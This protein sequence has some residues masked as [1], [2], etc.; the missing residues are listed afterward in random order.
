VSHCCRKTL[1][2]WAESRG[3]RDA[4]YN[5]FQHNKHARRFGR[6][7]QD[8]KEALAIIDALQR[9]NEEIKFIRSPH[10]GE[11]GVEMLRVLAKEEE[12]EL[13]ATADQ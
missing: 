6:R 11:F 3:R 1:R 2:W 7:C 5:C 4:I 12:E 8:G 10:E 13:P 9:R